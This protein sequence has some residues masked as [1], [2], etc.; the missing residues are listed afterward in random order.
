MMI[1]DFGTKNEQ[2]PLIIINHPSNV[3]NKVPFQTHL[4]Y[5]LTITNPKSKLTNPIN[6][7][8]A[9]EFLIDAVIFIKLCVN[10]SIQSPIINNKGPKIIPSH[11]AFAIANL[12]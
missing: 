5:R 6:Q 9:K 2:S 10:I 8:E 1:S 3:T 11:T 12:H 7:K 4:L